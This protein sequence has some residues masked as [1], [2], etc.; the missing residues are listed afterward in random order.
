M[1][2][3]TSI[4]L[5][6]MMGATLAAISTLSHAELKLGYVSSAAI[7]QKS[8]Q[9]IASGKKL[10][11]EFSARKN[12]LQ[13]EYNA[14]KKL[15]ENLAKLSGAERSKSLSD[16]A[17]RKAEF[18]R[19]QQQFTN[20][21]NNRRNEELGKLTKTVGETLAAIGKKEGFDMIFTDGV[22]YA[23]D[24]INLTDRVLRQLGTAK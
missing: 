2:K 6:L 23:K 7:L 8:P 3:N 20:D 5:S 4:V 15:D 14:I 9:A 21:L 13:T 16:I 24:S 11:Q 12:K 18:A 1:T 22:A 17:A 10:E 19:T